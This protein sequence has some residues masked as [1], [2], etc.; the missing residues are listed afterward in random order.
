MPFGMTTNDVVN[1]ANTAT[2]FSQGINAGSLSIAVVDGDGNGVGG[3]SVGF[4]ATSFSFDAQTTTGTLGI[5][6]QKIRLNN[7]T[8]TV[9]WSVTIGATGGDSAVWSDGGTN[10]YPYNNA[11]ADNGRLTVDPSGST[12]TPWS[13]CDNTNVSK[14][15]SDYFVTGSTS[16]IDLMTAA[17]GADPY[18]RWDLTSISLSQR[19]PAS[20]PAA[21]Y[22]LAM[23]ITAL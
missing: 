7:P 12:I 8:A 1:A 13:G 5:A 3:P 18:C 4:G 11:T 20:Q 10:T 16:S 2:T 15:S 17:T 23:T 19:I 14:G 21:T 9:T 22:T 6:A